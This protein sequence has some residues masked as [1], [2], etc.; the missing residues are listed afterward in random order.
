MREGTRFRVLPLPGNTFPCCKQPDAVPAAPSATAVGD[1]PAITRFIPA[2]RIAF[3]IPLNRIYGAEHLQIGDSIDLMASY[4]LERLRDEE[5]TETRPDGTV[6]VRKSESLTPR[7]TQR[8]WEES[9]GNRAEPWFVASDAIVVAPVGF[10]APPAALRAIEASGDS[11]QRDNNSKGFGGPPVIIAV[12]NRDVEAVATAL[13]TRDALFTVAFHSADSDAALPDRRIIAVAPES[14]DAFSELSD[15]AWQG[16]R[17]DVATRTVSAT[18]TRFA[19]ALTPEQ[20]SI[21]YGRVL[22][23]DKARGEFFTADDFLP[24]GVSEGVA[25]SVRNGFTLFADRRSRD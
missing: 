17:R 4:S 10:P 13:A 8:S 15:T 3:A 24:A 20:L 12:E 1:R 7:T 5:E 11:L 2:G 9:F 16:N 21:H 6:I 19:D 14:I 25:A 23:V 22:R 18:D